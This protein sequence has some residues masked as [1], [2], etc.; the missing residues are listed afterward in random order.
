VSEISDSAQVAV[1]V[2]DA[3][4]V[5]GSG[6]LN[7]LGGNFS[8]TSLQITGLTSSHSVVVL[9]DI[10]PKFYGD[11]F[12]FGLTLVDEA[13][14]PVELPGQGVLRVQQLVPVQRP[15]VQGAILPPTLPARAQI[16]MNFSSGLPLRPGQLYKWQV[17]IDGNKR[18]E[19]S[20]WF[21]ILG[22][23]PTP[24]LG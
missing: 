20:T 21:Y 18:P 22:P 16:A 4:S 10:P 24:V 14:Q 5:D 23:P 19:W 1:L 12:A 6:K 8:L 17:E 7:L 13:D 9:I 3:L 11:S 2:A 15:S